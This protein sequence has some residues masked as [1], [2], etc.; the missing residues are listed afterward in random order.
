MKLLWIYPEL[1]YPLT[2]GLLR[3]YYLL[4]E[5]G[6][7]HAISFLVLTHQWPVPAEAIP[8]LLPYAERV[9]VFPVHPEPE[10]RW[11]SSLTAVPAFGWRLREAYATRH[12]LLQMRER[13]RHL[14]A[15]EHFDVAL[16]SGR[17]AIPVL[18]VINVPLAVD[19]G[20]ANCGRLRQQMRYASLR[21]LPGLI[22]RCLQITHEEKLLARATTHRSFISIRDREGLLGADDRSEIVPQGIDYE[23]WARTTPPPGQNCIAFSGV[24]NYAPNADAAM[25]LLKDILPLVRQRVSRLKVLIIGRDPTPDLQ[26][27][28][29]RQEDVTVTGTAP[30]VR[31]WLEQA[32]VYVAALR[33][34]SGVQNKVLEAMSM[35]LPVVTTPVV[36]AGLR[37]N[38]AEPPVVVGSTAEE[39]A[40]GLIR[41]LMSGQERAHLA[42]EG[43]EYVETNCSW[44]ASAARLEKVC[45]AAAAKPASTYQAA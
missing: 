1:P 4:R 6:K 31:P 27:E 35:R 26:K 8:A 9:E 7:R 5:L 12:T 21:Q 41:L 33:F 32:D 24:M 36:A 17:E 10:P 43:R 29:A 20:D 40:S 25:F 14:L 18:D 28:A 23:Y 30:D 13:V 22:Y 11:L 37:L 19:I 2:S 45:M 15:T 39:L 38:H 3:G 44:S 42:S 16:F 34:A